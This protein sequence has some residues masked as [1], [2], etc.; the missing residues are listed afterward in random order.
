MMEQIREA[1]PLAFW[2]GRFRGVYDHL[3]REEAEETFQDLAAFGAQAVLEYGDEH[4][5]TEEQA[6]V[7]AIMDAMKRTCR[8]SIE[9]EKSLEAF[10]D[11]YMARAKD[12]EDQWI[13]PDHPRT[14]R[15]R[16]KPSLTSLKWGSNQNDTPSSSTQLSLPSFKASIG[17]SS[18]KMKKFCSRK[19][20]V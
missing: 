1:R 9:A 7:E 20:V 11:H 2:A 10:R 8:G 19:S 13:F 17:K 3:L 5:Q 12:D 15:P 16:W 18:G 14:K 4:A 6:R